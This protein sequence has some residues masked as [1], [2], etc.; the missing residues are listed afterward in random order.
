[1]HILS[2][3]PADMYAVAMN[4]EIQYLKS[5]ATGNLPTPFAGFAEPGRTD[6]SKLAH[7]GPDVAQTAPR[8]KAAL[9]GCTFHDPHTLSS[10]MSL[11]QPRGEAGMPHR[12]AGTHPAGPHSG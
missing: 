11:D 4:P 6:T 10:G 12:R 3:L 2:T 5:T 8:L 9:M 1:M 7:P